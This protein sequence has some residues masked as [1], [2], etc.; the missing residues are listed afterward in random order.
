[1]DLENKPVR[2]ES[3][4]EVGRWAEATFAEIKKMGA[5]LTLDIHSSKCRATATLAYC[6]V[7]FDVKSTMTGGTTMSQPSRNTVVLRKGDDGW[8]WMHWHSSLAPSPA[9]AESPAASSPKKK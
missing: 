7:E 9:P 4:D 3:R 8:K 2:L 6:T 1:M 5:V